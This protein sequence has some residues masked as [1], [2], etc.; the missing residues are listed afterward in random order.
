MEHSP[1]KNHFV[2]F[3]V[4]SAVFFVILAAS[5]YAVT[6]KWIVMQTPPAPASL[7][8]NLPDMAYVGLPRVSVSFGG[9]GTGQMQLQMALEVEPQHV[10]IVEGYI[11][12]IMDRFNAYFPKA[13]LDRLDRPHAMFLLHKDLLWQANQVGMPVPVNDV[14][15][16]K[17]VVQ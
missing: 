14:L 5:G 7:R 6:D 3:Y 10:E 12:R 8:P 16:Q 11:P 4:G 15:I 9:P 17:L 13:Q 2:R 1:E